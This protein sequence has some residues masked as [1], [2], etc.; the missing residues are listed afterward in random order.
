MLPTHD[1]PC[2]RCGRALYSAIS[3]D[4]GVN[5]G[6]VESPDVHA[7]NQGFYMTCPGCQVRVRMEKITAAGRE[8]FRLAA[9]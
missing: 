1:V 6:G 4:D 2:P 7:D 9:R 5:P 8:A 3:L